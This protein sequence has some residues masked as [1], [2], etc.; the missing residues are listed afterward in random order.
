M[1]MIHVEAAALKKHVKLLGDLGDV[2]PKIGI[3]YN[4]YKTLAGAA[5][6][7][8]FTISHHYSKSSL[9]IMKSY[10]WQ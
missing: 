5:F 7:T 9:N 2:D 8:C 4:I 1:N 6:S 10:I 3:Y